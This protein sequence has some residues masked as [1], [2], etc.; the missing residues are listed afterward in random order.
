MIQPT[1]PAGAFRYIVTASFS[2]VPRFRRFHVAALAC[3]LFALIL[4]AKLW[5]VDRFGSDIPNW[6]QWDAEGTN[7]FLPYF[8]HHLDFI[9]LFKPHN[10]HRIFFT[11]ALNLGLLLAGG[12]WDA[13]VQCVANAALHSAFA[14][15]I[16]LWF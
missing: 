12:Q 7:L 16:F 13:R 8:Q 3:C 4:G 2:K 11:K 5:V 14:V 6:D 1:G 15:M 9:D 10:E